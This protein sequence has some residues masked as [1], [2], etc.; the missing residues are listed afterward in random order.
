MNKR[1]SDSNIDALV[2][3]ELN[4][5][6]FLGIS[7]AI[8]AS[9][10]F[11]G[12]WPSESAAETG[13][14][15]NTVAGAARGGTLEAVVHP[16]PPTLAF[17]INTSTPGR[18]VVSKIFDGLFDYAPDLSPRPQ[19]AEKVA[20]SDDGLTVTLFLR[21]NVLWHDGQPF[22][23][24]DVKFSAEN[25]W[26]QYS[27]F[28]RRVFQYLSGVETPDDHTVILT[29]SKPTPVVLNALD[30]V[31]TPILP[32]HLYEGTDIPNN[33]YNNKPVGTGPF[34]FREWQRGSHIALE[35]FDKY[36]QPER[37][38]LDKL[39]FKIIPDV[40]GRATAFETGEIQYGERNP[41]TFADA[42]RLAKLP[43]LTLDTDGY[44]GF[45]TSF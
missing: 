2:E 24:A 17:F 28:A 18:T 12:I 6:K 7:G 34:V 15:P 10:V 16:E 38:F 25:V 35:R 36:W 23:A 11:G 22:S 19:L 30:V 44:N 3:Y 8:L 5:R 42:A 31:A 9:G 29:L 39:L 32:R 20:V 26:R 43:T 13:S 21:R 40:S 45:A 37:P 27:P 41:V 1:P 4:R 14:L 33:P